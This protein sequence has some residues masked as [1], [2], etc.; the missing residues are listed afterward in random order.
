MKYNGPINQIQT[1]KWTLV[2][3]Y[4]FETLIRD[5]HEKPICSCKYFFK[6]ISKKE[7]CG[8]FCGLLWIC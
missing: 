5:A 6:L 4:K 2:K 7:Y 8:M 1:D 3:D